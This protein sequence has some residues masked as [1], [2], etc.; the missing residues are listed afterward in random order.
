MAGSST[1]K[2]RIKNIFFYQTGTVLCYRLPEEDIMRTEDV[3]SFLSLI[4][5]T[6]LQKQPSNV[7]LP[8]LFRA[9]E[10]KETLQ[11]AFGRCHIWYENSFCSPIVATMMK[12]L[13]WMT[14]RRAAALTSHE[15]WEFEN[16]L[17]CISWLH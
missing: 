11:W 12:T 17:D 10:V 9:L 4:E 16:L 6:W 13:Y 7:S 8:P 3:M 5:H 14:Q 2:R 1:M 15:L